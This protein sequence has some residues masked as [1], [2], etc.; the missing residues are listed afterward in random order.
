MKNTTMK[1]FVVALAASLLLTQAIADKAHAEAD[2]F[3]LGSGRDGAVTVNAAN[4]VINSYASV[5]ANVAVGASTISVDTTTGFVAGNVVLVW[6]ATG[7]S[8]TDA[9]RGVQTTI[10]LAGKNVGHHEWARIES[11]G[12][13]TITLT[14]PVINA[15][16]S[17]TAQLVRVPEYTTVTIGA[18]GSIVASAWTGSK[19]GIVAF[20]ATGAIS[21]AGLI[22]AT[23]A[24]FRGGA[25]VNHAALDNCNANS[26]G[27]PAD[28]TPANGYS[29]KGEGLYP[30][31]YTATLGGR[32][33]YANGGGGGVCHN[34]GGGGGGHRGRGG[35]G[36]RTWVGDGMG[37]DLGGFGGAGLTYDPLLFL[38]MGGGGGAG[39]MNNNVGSGGGAGGGVILI[40]AASLSGAGFVR[41]NGQK[42][43]FNNGP[44]ANDA[45]GGGGAGGLIVLR[46]AGAAVCGGLEANGG[47]GGDVVTG[48]EHGTGGGGGGGFIY[49]NSASGTCNGTANAG[50]AGLWTGTGMNPATSNWN[51]SPVMANDATSVGLVTATGMSFSGTTCSAANIAA[52]QCGGCIAFPECPGATPVCSL[53]TNACTG[54]TAN[55][56]GSGALACPGSGSP[57]CISSGTLAG[58]CVECGSDANCVG[59]LNGPLCDTTKGTCGTCTAGNLGACTGTSPTCNTTPTHNLCAA[60]NGDRGSAATRACPNAATPA[61]VTSGAQTGA[62]VECLGNSHCAGNANGTVCDTTKQLCGACTAANL[63][64]CTGNTPTCNTAPTR[65]ICQACNGNFG[66]A[67][68][69]ACPS[70]GTPL[71]ALSGALAGACVTCLGNNDCGGATPI[72]SAAG[73]CGGCNGD[74][75]S[76]TTLRC[77]M[78][79][80]FCSLGTGMCSTMCTSDPQCGA[81]NWCNSGACQPLIPN[82]GALPGGV[83]SALLGGRACLTGVCDP[84]DNLCGLLKGSKTCP[85]TAACRAGL[86]VAAGANAGTCLDCDTDTNCSGNTPVCNSASNLCVACTANN[87]ASCLNPTP[88]CNTTLSTCQACN[89]DMGSQATS[90]CPGGAAPYCAATGACG[91]CTQNAD[92]TTGTHAGPICNVQTGSCGSMCQQD[93]DC[94]ATEWCNSGNCQPKLPNGDAI[95]GG[96]CNASLGM[97]ACI[98][99]A[100]AANDGRCGLPNGELC[101]VDAICRS[102]DCFTDGRCGRPVNEPCTGNDICRALV[103]GAGGTCGLPNNDPCTTDAVCR[104]GLCFSDKRC[105][106]PLG[107]TCSTTSVCRVGQCKGLVCALEPDGGIIGGTMDAGVDAMAPARDAAVDGNRPSQ[108]AGASGG[109]GGTGGTGGTDDPD[110]MGGAAGSAFTSDLRVGGGGCNCGVAGT[111]ADAAESLLLFVLVTLHLRRRR[112][113]P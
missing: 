93:S 94:S 47:A 103:C 51:A 106:A 83:C 1:P 33:N 20:L 73:S 99:G 41:A 4:T 76:M 107:E 12:T 31:G 36:G 3:G 55:F 59:N 21:N 32:S 98:S 61:C 102:G 88:I 28:D 57:I 101:Q 92:C 38:S 110:D 68:S 23:N 13:N 54:C 67:A 9:P 40:R 45:A 48:G 46:I 91:K 5:T 10:A 29:L 71:C 65:N 111:R 80:P 70:M 77:P 34:S 2:S 63:G 89:G 7:L 113:K 60:C 56:G 75:A 17:G 105:G 112:K 64:A 24:G 81:G 26:M 27:F 82:G 44:A 58:Q 42:P 104:T 96:V 16:R 79:T 66:T 39:D 86:C 84:M 43:T 18:A 78:N 25:L 30:A 100:C 85:S 74:F 49:L 35:N 22:S 87:S 14:N 11:I 37:R 69:A 8:A 97:R 52:G 109:A 15:Y 19:G 50:V 72:C 108:D 90:P 53:V 62:C 95:P 6:Q